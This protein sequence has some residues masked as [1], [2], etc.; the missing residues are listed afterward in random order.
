MKVRFLEQYFFEAVTSLFG[1][2]PLP[3]MSHMPCVLIFK[4]LLLSANCKIDKFRTRGVSQICILE[5]F[6]RG[7]FLKDFAKFHENLEQIKNNI[8]SLSAKN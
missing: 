3:H 4:S 5:W 7:S 8:D 6:E 2:D 1:L